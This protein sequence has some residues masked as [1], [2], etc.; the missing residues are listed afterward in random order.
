MWKKIKTQS[1]LP[2]GAL[3]MNGGRTRDVPEATWVGQRLPHEICLFLYLQDIP[4]LF[5]YRQMHWSVLTQC[6]KPIYITQTVKINLHTMCRN[7]QW[8]FKLTHRAS[9]YILSVSLQTECVITRFDIDKLALNAWFL[10][11]V[12][13]FFYI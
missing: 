4:Q 1:K 8:V 7:T 10:L 3:S 6:C 12:A 11:L 13:I 2:S 9:K 5:V